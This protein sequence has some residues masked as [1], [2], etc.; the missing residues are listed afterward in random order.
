M[1][2][3][4]TAALSGLRALVGMAGAALEARDDAKAKQ[5][6]A[7]MSERL[8]GAYDAALGLAENARALR[9][10]ADEAE[11]DLAKL[12]AQLSERSRYQLAKVSATGDFFAYQL[13]PAA[14][15]LERQDEPMHFLCQPCFDIR[16]HKAVLKTV[17]IGLRRYMACPSCDDKLLLA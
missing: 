3:E 13:R 17:P 11:A 5:A 14:E 4:I 16:G 10:C 1:N 2:L 12:K 15:L 6:I 8:L 9:M 7:D